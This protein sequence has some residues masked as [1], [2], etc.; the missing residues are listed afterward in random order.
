MTAA[1]TTEAGGQPQADPLSS[2]S[3]VV[4]AVLWHPSLWPAAIRSVLRLAR[5]GWWR[6]WPPLPVPGTRYWNFRVSTAMGG[7]VHAASGH[8]DATAPMAPP[9]GGG[10]LSVEDVRDY[11]RWCRGWDRL[12]R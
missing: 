8:S 4:R 6:T 9:G 5:K 7:T 2:A 3:V 11:L 10:H 12:S 1:S